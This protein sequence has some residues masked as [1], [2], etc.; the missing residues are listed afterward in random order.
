MTSDSV[1]LSQTISVIHLPPNMLDVAESVRGLRREQAEVVRAP[2]HVVVATARLLRVRVDCTRR[3]RVF[4]VGGALEQLP[5]VPDAQ[6]RIAGAAVERARGQVLVGH[7]SIKVLRATRV[8]VHAADHA[9]SSR[10]VVVGDRAVFAARR[11]HGAVP[12]ETRRA[13]LVSGERA[14]SLVLAG[15]PDL[16]AA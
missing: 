15:V 12:V 2:A 16:D 3:L 1:C 14:Q 4:V 10:K 13:Q 9:V 5:D 7:V 6:D 8:Q 11:Q